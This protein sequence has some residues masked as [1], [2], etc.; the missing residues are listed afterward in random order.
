[1][2]DFLE[3]GVIGAVSVTLAIVYFR[4]VDK[5]LMHGEQ[6]DLDN[7]KVSKLYQPFVYFLALGVCAT[8]ISINQFLSSGAHDEALILTAFALLL[9]GFL[10]IHIHFGF[11]TQVSFSENELRVKTLLGESTV[12]LYDLVSV[13]INDNCFTF[14]ISD[15][16][17]TARFCHYVVGKRAV[18]EHILNYAPAKSTEELQALIEKHSLF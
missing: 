9:V 14:V 11:F 2:S 10:L 5:R 4:W 1:M 18:I 15:S 6:P 13:S 3:G 8:C 12:D 17:S 16:R 7:I